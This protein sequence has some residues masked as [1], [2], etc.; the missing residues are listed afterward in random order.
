M[1]FNQ[2]SHITILVSLLTGQA[3]W[4]MVVLR[5]KQDPAYSYVEFTTQLR[6]A[7]QHPDSVVVG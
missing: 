6:A 5:A 1:C 2:R 4:A 7:F 3:V